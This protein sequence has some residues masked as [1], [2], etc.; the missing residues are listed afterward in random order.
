MKQ[1]REIVIM[2]GAI[3][4]K[5]NVTP[6]AEF[7]FFADPMAAKMVLESGIPVTLVPLDVTHQVS[8]TPEIIEKRVK[9]SPDP[10]SRFI[11]EA[12]GYDSQLRQFRGAGK[13]FHLHDPLAVGAV[14]N[15]DLVRMESLPLLVETAAGEQYGQVHEASAERAW[16]EQKVAVCLGVKAEKFLELFLSRLAG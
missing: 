7:N 6:Y 9:A 5:G 16:G 1:L 8:L 10:F 15:P 11:L 3:R 14:I 13:A 4:E 12:T 2:G